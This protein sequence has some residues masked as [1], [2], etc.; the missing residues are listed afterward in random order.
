MCVFIERKEKGDKNNC[1][2]IVRVSKKK[3]GKR[4]KIKGIVYG[5]DLIYTQH[6][7]IQFI[8][9]FLSSYFFCCFTLS[10]MYVC[11]LLFNKFV[12]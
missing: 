1:Y 4:E 9:R 3:G 11:T 2:V 8:I 5:P 7:V 10:Y 6:P 12:R